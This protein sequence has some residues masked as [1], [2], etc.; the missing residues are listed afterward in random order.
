L[1]R[2]LR[3][4]WGLD[5]AL[6][7]ALVSASPD[8]RGPRGEAP[9]TDSGQSAGQPHL[10]RMAVQQPNYAP[11][12]GYFAKMF[13][14][15]AFVFLDDAQL[16]QGRSL[17]SRVKIAGRPETEHWLTVPVR[18][19][20]RPIRD[21]AFADGSW[22]E[23]HLRTLRQVYGKTPH[24]AEVMEL[25]RP[26][27][28]AT[29]TSLADFNMRLIEGVASYLGYRGDFHRSSDHPS[30]LRADARIAELVAGVGGDVYVSGAGGQNY[31]SEAVY[32][33]QGVGLEVRTYEPVPYER[34]GLGWIGGLSILDALFH[35]GR[36]ARDVLRYELD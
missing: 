33:E 21:V 20:L 34:S 12:C 31:Q 7:V 26:F 14:C 28:D 13:A 1:P 32:A 18:K 27:Y 11:W 17:V 2:G 30:D 19:G 23:T 25:I 24:F 16:P 35:R 6:V 9:R 15:D 8:A 29:G 22:A 10:V 5:L 36:S 4:T 3:S